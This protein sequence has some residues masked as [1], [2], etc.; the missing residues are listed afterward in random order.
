[1]TDVVLVTQSDGVRTL[2]L[3]RP[4]SL[5]ALPLEAMGA[6]AD[7]LEEAAADRATRAVIIT[8]AGSAFSAGGDIAFL[9]G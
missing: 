2:R 6:L 1:M 7:R 9:N 5:N 4:D 3:N 8:G